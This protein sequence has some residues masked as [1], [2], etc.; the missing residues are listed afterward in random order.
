MPSGKL[1]PLVGIDDPHGA[2][3]PVVV[4]TAGEHDSAAARDLAGI[5]QQVGPDALVS[6]QR[7]DLC[8]VGIDGPQLLRAP[9]RLVG[10]LP[11][12]VDDAAVVEHRGKV[13]GFV[14]LRHQVDVLPI[15]IAAGQ[16]E[17]I[18]RRHAS[19]VRVSA[20][21][22]EHQVLTVRQ[23]D[24]IQIVVRSVG[25]LPQSAAVDIDLVQVERLLVVRLEAEQ[26]LLRIPR[27]IGTPEGTM[28]RQLR[29]QL[30]QMPVR[31]QPVQD[32]QSSAGNRHVTESMSRLVGPF[33][34]SRETA[35]RQT[36]P[37]GSRRPDSGT[38]CDVSLRAHGSTVPHPDPAPV[39]LAAAV[40]RASGS[41]SASRGEL[42]ATAGQPFGQLLGPANL[43]ENPVAGRIPVRLVQPVA[44]QRL[45]GLRGREVAR[46]QVF[47]VGDRGPPLP[48]PPGAAARGALLRA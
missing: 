33:A 13:I 44:L 38:R 34:P 46:E 40:S 4:S 11:P 14:V 24:R 10:I 47:P 19:H 6:P 48:R 32:E 15:R 29:H 28:Q 20:R 1:K 22:G 2:G 35:C 5:F 18:G 16:D 8:S 30:A 23:V 21:R 7:V 45:A 37:A 36:G 41:S 12:R 27:Q 3:E 9:Q 43:G 26:H 17:G 42:G 25:Q 39:P 31:R